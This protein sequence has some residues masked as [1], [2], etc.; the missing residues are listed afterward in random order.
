MD[1]FRKNN[2]VT[3]SL[4]KKNLVKKIC[5]KSQMVK[6]LGSFF[7]VGQ[8]TPKSNGFWNCWKKKEEVLMGRNLEGT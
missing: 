2:F 4:R 8:I 7:K 5:E 6:E 3:P 1:P